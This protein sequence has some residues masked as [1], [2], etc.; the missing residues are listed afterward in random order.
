M[1]NLQKG[2]VSLPAGEQTYILS[3]SVNAFCHLEEADGRT[4]GE[5]IQ[6]LM[7]PKKVSIRQLRQFVHAGLLDHHPDLSLTDAGRIIML[8]GGVNAVME[9][10]GRGLESSLPE[11]EASGTPRPPNRA[12]RRKAGTGPAS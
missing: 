9:A 1:A 7:D 11:K 4:F 3:Y 10:V 8:A 6:E 5:I 12:D 2:E